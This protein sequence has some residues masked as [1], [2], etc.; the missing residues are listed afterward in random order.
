MVANGLRAPYFWMPLDKWTQLNCKLRGPLRVIG[1][2]ELFT[3]RANLSGIF[4][5]RIPALADAFHGAFLEMNEEGAE[6]SEACEEVVVGGGPGLGEIT[7]FIVNRPFIFLIKPRHGTV[8]PCA[9][10]LNNTLRS[11]GAA[12]GANSFVM[13]DRPSYRHPIKR[14]LHG[15]HAAEN[16]AAQ[17][18]GRRPDQFPSTDR[19]FPTT[20]GHD[21][22]AQPAHL[23][24]LEP[25]IVGLAVDLYRQLVH[26]VEGDRVHEDVARMAQ[27]S[28]ARENVIF[29]PVTVA[30][31]LSMT[32]AGARCETAEEIAYALHTPNDG[33]IHR[34]FAAELARITIPTAGITFK[35]TSR[36]YRDR[37]CPVL[38]SYETF[39]HDTY[40]NDIVHSVDFAEGFLEVRDEVNERMAIGTAGKIRELLTPDC[41]GPRTQLM[42]ITGAYFDGAWEAPFQPT[43]TGP[44]DFHVDGHTVV[45]VDMMNQMHSFGIAHCDQLQATALEMPHLG[46]KTSMVLI[47]PDQMDGLSRLEENLTAQRLSDLLHGL[48]ERPNVMVKMPK[49]A[50]VLSRGLRRALTDLGV[51]ELFTPKANLSGIFKAGS[52]ALDDIFHGAFLEVN[53]EGAEM[54]PPSSDEAVLGGG[55]GVGDITHFVVN[56]PFMFI[57]GL[58]REKVF[59]LMGSVRRP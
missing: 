18:G 49:F 39:L 17:D 38:K 4:E 19:N 13:T 3:T 45:R 58:R 32:L 37:N 2:P 40:G 46:G 28:C 36:L 47:L 21:K 15:S 56:H 43:F 5:T 1:V 8:G 20:N 24:T 9:N 27:N 35:T 33:Q 34:L 57:V 11:I 7:R 41:I 51:R 48:R 26:H 52:T 29:S 10:A 14:L 6:S 42:I 53:E 44:D 23:Q 16:P 22:A 25:V 59:Y 12:R 55:P 54:P 30:A 31:A 50:V